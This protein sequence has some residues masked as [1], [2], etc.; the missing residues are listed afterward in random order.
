MSKKGWAFVI[1]LAFFL[2]IGEA[3]ALTLLPEPWR[4]FRPVLDCIVMLIVLRRPKGALLFAAI[5]GLVLDAFQVDS[6]GFVFGRIVCVAA[7]L[8]LLSNSLLTNRSLYASLA[9]ALGARMIEG[10]WL[11]SAH[12]FGAVLFHWDIPIMPF[13][14]F[15]ITSVWDV[16][17][18]GVTFLIFVFF[19][20][21]FFVSA[22]R[23]TPFYEQL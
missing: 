23:A 20:R 8:V 16:V 22:H 10:I 2:A 19:T 13:T 17:S 15:L 9:L 1:V 5:A 12:V 6:S 21:R 18:V 7:I 3:T 11:L 14:S 4:D